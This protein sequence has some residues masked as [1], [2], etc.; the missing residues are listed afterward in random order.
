MA[1]VTDLP[2]PQRYRPALRNA[3]WW[4]LLALFY[5]AAFRPLVM[6]LQGLALGGMTSLLIAL[7]FHV[8]YGLAGYFAFSGPQWL[9]Q[10]LVF[11][12]LLANGIVFELL[13][14]SYLYS[15]IAGMFSLGLFAAGGVS[16]GRLLGKGGAWCRLRLKPRQ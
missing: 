15:S 6:F 1:G 2:L 12:A 5:A 11:G 3:L 9:R 16:L 13:V 7:G 10:A 8:L 14:T 4:L